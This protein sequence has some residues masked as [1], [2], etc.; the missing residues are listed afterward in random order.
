MGIFESDDDKAT[1][2]AIKIVLGKM[3]AHVRREVM[4]DI[5]GE[6][7]ATVRQALSASRAELR[8]GTRTC[9]S[10]RAGRHGSCAGQGCACG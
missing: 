1:A 8:S 9:D 4:R 2:A 6:T 10:C 5:D 7:T 3:P